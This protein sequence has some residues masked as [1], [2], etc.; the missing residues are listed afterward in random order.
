MEFKELRE[1][2]WGSG[3]DISV[4]NPDEK[5]T[6]GSICVF[7]TVAAALRRAPSVPNISGHWRGED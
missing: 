2:F 4:T 7:G 5:F 1:T 3:I 6:R